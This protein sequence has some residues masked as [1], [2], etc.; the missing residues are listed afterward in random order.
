MSGTF[1]FQLSP[2]VYPFVKN[3][4]VLLL[5]TKDM[6]AMIFNEEEHV[7]TFMRELLKPS[8]FGVVRL[9]TTTEQYKN[10]K[11]FIDKVCEMGNGSF[12]KVR[13]RSKIS[14][15]LNPYL[16]KIRTPAPGAER[17]ENITLVLNH[18]CPHNCSQCD[19]YARQF[20]SCSKR[21]S[22]AVMDPDFVKSLF[23][24]LS[25]PESCTLDVCGGDLSLHPHLDRMIELFSSFSGLCRYHIHCRQYRSSASK[26]PENAGKVIIV[27]FPVMDTLCFE[28][29]EKYT[30]NFVISQKEDL[31]LCR[32]YVESYNIP[33]FYISIMDASRSNGFMKKSIFLLQDELECSLGTFPFKD[34]VRIINSHY[35]YKTFILPNGDVYESSVGGPIA[36]LYEE[37]PSNVMDFVRSLHIQSW[38][39]ARNANENFNVCT[40]CLFYDMCPGLW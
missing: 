33:N 5:N 2:Y 3:N 31:T 28:H 29:P 22:N 13:Q 7:A 1:D 27:D 32:D 9:D 39:K 4:N 20:T 24:N 14:P 36:N 38:E 6:N 23:R 34:K 40:D 12:Q 16:L 26:L 35:F 18:D 17:G 8:S 37:T 19:E 30:Y 21:N 25:N 10:C 11:T 15:L